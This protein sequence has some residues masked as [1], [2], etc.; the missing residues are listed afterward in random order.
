MPFLNKYP[1][2]APVRSSNISLDGIC[3]NTLTIPAK[4][5]IADITLAT[6]VLSIKLNDRYGL[7]QTFNL[8]CVVLD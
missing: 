4:I 3:K 7:D 1:I 6:E 8:F 5:I 2:P